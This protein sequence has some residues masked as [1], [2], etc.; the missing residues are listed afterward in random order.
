M[1]T[2]LKNYVTPILVILHAVGLAGMLAFPEMNMKSIS[3]LNLITSLLLIL[4]PAPIDQLYKKIGIVFLL[5]LAVEVLGV[6]T[7][8]PFG[9]YH[10]GESLGRKVFEVPLVIG[11]NWFLTAYISYHV[12]KS[13]L[14]N[15]LARIIASTGLMLI[16]DFL[17]EPVAPKLDYWYWA[18]DI[19]PTMN[20]VSWYLV[21]LACV[22][23]IDLN[24]QE[25]INRSARNLFFI[26]LVFF[27]ALNLFL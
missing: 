16:L 26:Q 9:S 13:F 24:N 27:A 5:G 14:K 20:F 17:I 25:T 4:L 6:S 2:R 3:S 7:G 11:I 8:Y 12:A 19:I 18:D 15:Q 10:Y 23:I 21:G 1:F 22:Y